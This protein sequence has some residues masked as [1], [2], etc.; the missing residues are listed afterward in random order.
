[1]DWKLAE[2]VSGKAMSRWDDEGVG[3]RDGKYNR[4]YTAFLPVK[5]V[6]N[7]RGHLTRSGNGVPV[8]AGAPAQLFLG[9]LAISSLASHST[10]IDHLI[11]TTVDGKSEEQ[12]IVVGTERRRGLL[13]GFSEPAV[14]PPLCCTPLSRLQSQKFRMPFVSSETHASEDPTFF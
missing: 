3:E 5:A 1:M 8:R 7:S 12:S 13:E 2:E 6:V 10:I 14:R 9:R 4:A 11:P